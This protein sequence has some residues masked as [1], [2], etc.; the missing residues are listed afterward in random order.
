QWVEMKTREDNEFFKK[1]VKEQNTQFQYN[2]C[3]DSLVTAE[4][5][6]G[7]GPGDVFVNRNISNV[8]NTHDISSTAVIQYAL[9]HLKV[10]H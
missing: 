10:K 9:E 5:M 3:S 8:V 7:L 6:M 1:N 4:E 2:G